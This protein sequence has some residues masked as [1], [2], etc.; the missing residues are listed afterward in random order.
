VIGPSLIW[1]AG[2]KAI[3]SFLLNAAFKARLPC[4]NEGASWISVSHMRA[5]DWIDGIVVGMETSK[6]VAENITYSDDDRCRQ[7]S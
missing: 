1:R 5:Q 4:S 7:H 6:Q 3:F 2:Q